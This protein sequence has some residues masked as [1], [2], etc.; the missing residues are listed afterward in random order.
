MVLIQTLVRTTLNGNT[1]KIMTA[2]LTALKL[3][4]SKRN[5]K[6]FKDL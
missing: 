3:Q 5:T 2:H 1:T 4:I 6:L